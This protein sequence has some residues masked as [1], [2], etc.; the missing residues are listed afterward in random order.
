MRVIA[1]PLLLDLPDRL[2]SER[3]LL[4]ASR[5]GDGPVVN[6]GVRETYDELHR[7]MPWA[8]TVP[9]V[10]ESEE[11]ARR[12]QADFI[13]RST[14]DF[15][16]FRRDDTQRSDVQAQ[17]EG[18]FVGRIGIW[19]LDWAVPS[20]EIGYWCRHCAQRRGFTSE[21]VGLVTS[22]AWKYLQARR[23][24]IRCDTRN[25]G[26]QKVAQRAGF[27]HEATL[28]QDARANDGSLR[29]TAVFSLLLEDIA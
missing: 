15:N 17:G 11:F 26:S 12:A 2:S 6:A 25:L 8:R 29:D 4:R 10:E 19:P 23:L 27:S 3:L 7:W 21:A 22:W 9:S 1:R 13:A 14:F 16:I 18:L 28:R 5:A 20:F 24:V